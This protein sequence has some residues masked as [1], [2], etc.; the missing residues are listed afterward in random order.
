MATIVFLDG[1]DPITGSRR[2]VTFDVSQAGSI[3]KRRPSPVNHQ[4]TLR[5]QIRLLLKATNQYFWNLT[6]LQRLAWGAWAFANGI[7]GPYGKKAEQGGCAGFFSLQLNARIAGDSFYNT[8]PGN[9]PLVGFTPLTLTRIAD[10]TIRLTFAPSPT[11]G[12]RR[13]YIRQAFPGPGYRRWSV[14]DGY[15][16]EYSAKNVNSPYDFT[17]K[18]PHLAGWH[19]RYWVAVQNK[20]GLRTV[21]TLFDL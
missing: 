19:C 1:I 18:F 13:L 14:Y 8:P 4:T 12:W 5:M 9:Q 21:E 16:A 7:T 6:K 20:K 11:G 10:Y 2:G 15:V 17:I 3:A